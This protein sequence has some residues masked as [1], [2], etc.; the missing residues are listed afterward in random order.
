MGSKIIRGGGTVFY[1]D[2]PPKKIPININSTVREERYLRCQVVWSGRVRGGQT[3]IGWKN[4]RRR[5]AS[6]GSLSLMVVGS[7]NFKQIRR[8]IRGREDHHRAGKGGGGG[9]GSIANEDSEGD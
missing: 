5:T 8:G 4:V 6:E 1:Q 7:L 9:S 3:G 2:P